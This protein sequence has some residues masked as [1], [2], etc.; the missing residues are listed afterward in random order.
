MNRGEWGE[1]YAA[2]RLLGDR[3]LFLSDEDGNANPNEWME[4]LKVVRQETADR[5]VTYNCNVNDMNVDVVVNERHVST[6]PAEYFLRIA[7]SLKEDICG[8]K[9]R[10]F[11][12]SDEVLEFIKGAEMHHLKAK[13]IEKSDIFISARDPRN[14]IVRENIGFSIKC[15]FGE[16]PTLFNTAKASAAKYR[17]SGMNSQ[18]M[19][20]VNSI[21][22]A[23]GHA[24]V[25]GR[26]ALLRENGCDLSFVGY[27][28]APRAKCCA[29]QENLDQINPRL[30]YVIERM[31]W[32]HFMSGQTEIDIE[33]VTNRIITE[34][35]C[36]ISLGESKY[37]YMVKMFLYSA[38][39]GMTASTLW[40]GRSNVK[41]GY[42][43]VKET[44]EVVANYALESESFKNFLFK[45]CYLDFPSTDPKHGDYG[46]VYE[47]NGE[48][49]FKLNFQV[50]IK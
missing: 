36:D 50:R 14:S 12:V 16:N 48:Y 17:I 10:S 28:Y 34:N 13:S 23:K 29:F 1:P 33:S 4:V 20:R 5:L 37:P 9:G 42:I 35:P 3:K 19:D 38:Y 26:C 31:M 39:C 11:N 43:T 22:D 49:Y 41:G 2:L 25:T 8:A 15:E 40:D 7:E 45:H 18:L 46:R 24:S 32:N 27:E 21:I 30:P 47:E 6:I 44:G